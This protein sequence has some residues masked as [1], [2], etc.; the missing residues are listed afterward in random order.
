MA[1]SVG[2]IIEALRDVVKLPFRIIIG[3]LNAIP[4]NCWELHGLRGNSEANRP[5]LREVAGPSPDRPPRAVR[6]EEQRLTPQVRP[7]ILGDGEEIDIR[8][9]QSRQAQTLGDRSMREAGVMFDAPESFFFDGRNQLTVAQNHSRHIA[10]VRVEA[11]DDGGGPRRHGRDAASASSSRERKCTSVNMV[12]NRISPACPR[13]R[14]VSTS[15]NKR[16]MA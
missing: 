16:V 13:R 11:E 3:I 4:V 12:R 10:V 1:V 8:G 9:L 6:E 14:Q 7:R 5:D 15:S 2:K